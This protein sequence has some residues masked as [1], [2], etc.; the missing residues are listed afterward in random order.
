MSK[1][2]SD[3]YGCHQKRNEWEDVFADD[4]QILVKKIIA[5][6]P[7]FRGEANEQLKHQYAHKVQ[8]QYYAAIARSVLQ[9]SDHIES[10]TQ[11]CSHLALTFGSCNKSGRISSQ[12]TVIET[13]AL[14][15]SE[16]LCRAVQG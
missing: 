14:T 11:F 2:I 5:C 12:A 13:T 10:F 1:L 4:I 3:F 8:D 9:T 6:K 16:V 7:S 15:I